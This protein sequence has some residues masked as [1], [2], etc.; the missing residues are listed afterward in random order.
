MTMQVK[1]AHMTIDLSR[2]E[3][4]KLKTLATMF[5][6]S[7]RELVLQ[8]VER[9]LKIDTIGESLTAISKSMHIQK[10]DVQS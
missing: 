2:K 8:A 10:E 1:L 3:H 6:I 4:K 5:G 7:M 9:Y